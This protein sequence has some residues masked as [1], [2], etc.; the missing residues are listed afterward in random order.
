ML[1]IHFYTTLQLHYFP[2]P[3]LKPAMRSS[4]TPKYGFECLLDAPGTV[5]GAL[6]KSRDQNEGC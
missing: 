6:N 2:Y 1:Q 5:Q 4:Q 3:S